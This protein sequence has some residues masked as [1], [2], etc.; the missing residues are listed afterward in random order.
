MRASLDEGSRSL[1][2]VGLLLQSGDLTRRQIPDLWASI[3][4][5][6]DGIGESMHDPPLT[7]LLLTRS[8][9]LLTTGIMASILNILR[10]R[11][12]SHFSVEPRLES[13]LSR[14]RIQTKYDQ[15]R[16]A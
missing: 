13:N 6:Y 2:P 10:D 5:I 16:L 7:T 9:P 1:A 4:A 15:E 12:C 3:E 11:Q 8:P 14:R